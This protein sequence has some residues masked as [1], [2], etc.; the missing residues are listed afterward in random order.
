MGRSRFGEICSCFSL[1]VLPS[2]ALVPLMH[3]F[4]TSAR[5]GGGVFGSNTDS[6]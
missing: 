5:R 4:R 3:S 2:P 6:K 1:T